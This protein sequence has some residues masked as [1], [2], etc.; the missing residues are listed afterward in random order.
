MH[1]EGNNNSPYTMVFAH[2]FGCD[3]TAWDGV[4]SLFTNNYKLVLFDNAGAGK[5]HQ[6]AHFFVKYQS[7]E[8][9]VLDFL[10]IAE[11]LDLKDIIFVGHSVSA[12]VG[13][14][15][16]L[17]A[18][19]L[20]SKLVLIGASPRY[21]NDDGYFG[22]FSQKALNSLYMQMTNGY[23][24]WASGFSKITMA[25]DDNPDLASSFSKS[26]SALRP[27]IALQVA[28]SIFESDFRDILPQINHE[29]LLVRSETDIVVPESVSIYL[30]E[31]IKNSSLVTVNAEG[32]FPHM[33]A[34]L[35]IAKVIQEFI[36]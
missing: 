25:N 28:K 16:S 23:L 34:P 36:S 11:T 4:K 33:S 1:I 20:F 22:G 13:L 3:Q 27:D 12:M 14:L 32:H 7:L 6:M 26:L 2:G 18:P 24:Q 35:E 9:Y 21:L 15:A 17:H 10:K 29:V 19:N 30:N 31:Q 8:G 5:A